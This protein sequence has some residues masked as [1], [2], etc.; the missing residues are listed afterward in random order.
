LTD[1]QFIVEAYIRKLSYYVISS[2]FFTV[3]YVTRLTS[4]CINEDEPPPWKFSLFMFQTIAPKELNSLTTI[5]TFSWFGGA[6]V[7]HPLWLREVPGSI[8]GSGNAFSVWF[9][10]LL[11]L[12]LYFFVKNTLFVTQLCNFF[13]KFHY[14]VYLTFCKI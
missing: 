4:K 14:L 10:V 2:S 5:V 1:S 6:E 9:F 13:C 11:L 8:P 12:C 3:I 7:T